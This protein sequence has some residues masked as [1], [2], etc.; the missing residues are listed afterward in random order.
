[1]PFDDVTIDQRG[2]ARIEPLRH[3]VF[4]LHVAELF[5]ENI[6]LLDLEPFACR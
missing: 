2:M 6:L 1:M 4:A 3:T 5:S